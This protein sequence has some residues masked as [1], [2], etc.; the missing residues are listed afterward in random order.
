MKLGIWWSFASVVLETMN[1]W[2]AF[3]GRPPSITAIQHNPANTKVVNGITYLEGG[4]E[5]KLA[6]HADGNPEPAKGWYKDGV[7]IPEGVSYLE[8]CVQTK[9]DAGSG[10]LTLRPRGCDRQRHNAALS[11]EFQCRATNELGTAISN[12]SR[13]AIAYINLKSETENHQ[14]QIVRE[15]G[16]SKMVCSDIESL[17]EAEY[18]HY[19]QFRS[20]PNERWQSVLVNDKVWAG[21]NTL[22]LLNISQLNNGQYRCRGRNEVARSELSVDHSLWK[23]RVDNYA[24]PVSGDVH[25]IEDLLPSEPSEILVQKGESATLKCFVFG[26]PEVKI[27]WSIGSGRRCQGN[28]IP[29]HEFRPIQEDDGTLL[30]NGIVVYRNF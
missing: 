18:K 6:C 17:P 30:K 29:S 15:G 19:W 24:L 11:G 12:V 3:Q 7:W 16:A 23:I 9:F 25:V 28:D 22:I 27:A 26:H 2:P 20:T 21:G 1:R 8:E 13:L 10:V 5:F 4:K 14:T